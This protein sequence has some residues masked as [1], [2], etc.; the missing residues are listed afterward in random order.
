MP[1]LSALVF[2]TVF[3]FGLGVAGMT[4]PAKIIGFLDV[5][6]DWDPTLLF[7]MGGAVGLTGLVFPWVLRRRGP[8]LNA[9]FHL[10]EHRPLDARL[11]LGAALF[12]IG[13]GL[14]GYCP[15]PAIVSLVTGSGSVA[16]FLLS[17]VIGLLLGRRLRPVRP[18]TE[19]EHS[20][21]PNVEPR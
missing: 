18:P 5:A 15:G 17:M 9:S 3:A 8:L 6:G 2:G 12:G 19:T 20:E 7:V 13:W 4:Q 10:P 1:V 14:S 11:V 21:R 16:A